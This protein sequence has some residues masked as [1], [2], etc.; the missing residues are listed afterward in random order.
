MHFSRSVAAVLDLVP[1]ASYQPL[2]ASIR[3]RSKACQLISTLLKEEHRAIFSAELRA[4]A[5]QSRG[6]ALKREREEQEARAPPP[7]KA[8]RLA[9]PEESSPS[10]SP[11]I[12]CKICF[13][14]STEM[15]APRCGHVC[16]SKCWDTALG[17]SSKCPTCRAPVDRESLIVL[18]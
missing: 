12:V 3:D 16:C 9:P 13:E 10:A 17:S 7:P 6:E 4:W 11:G 2:K 14:M 5:E 1:D 8:P 18:H 15:L